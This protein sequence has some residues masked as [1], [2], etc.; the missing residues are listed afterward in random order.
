MRAY[1]KFVT[2]EKSIFMRIVTRVTWSCYNLI[3]NKW[4]ISM[5]I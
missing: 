4:L 1:G 5:L 2:F 3:L